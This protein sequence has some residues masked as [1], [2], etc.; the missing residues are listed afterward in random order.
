MSGLI[1]APLDFLEA[2]AALQLPPRAKRRLQLLM[3]RNNDGALTPE[4]RDE[5]GAL[6]ELAET[7]APLRSR[8]LRL[9][10]RPL[11]DFP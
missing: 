2:V 3:D 10:G 9:L 7:L 8:A 1:K 4:E 6:V 11:G 5:L